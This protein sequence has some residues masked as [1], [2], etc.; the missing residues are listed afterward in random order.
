VQNRTIGNRQV[1]AIGLGGMPMS[2]EGRPEREQSIA[3]IHAALDAGITL[4]DT[5]DAYCLDEDDKHHNEAL[6]RR[7]LA[8]FPGDTSQV[9]VAT[10]GGLVRPGGRWERYGDPAHLRR[11]IRESHQALGGDRPIG[12]W[13]LHAPD[14]AWTLAEMLEPV[15]EA[16]ERGLVQYVGLSNVTLAELREAQRHVEI[17]SVQNQYNPW[18]READRSGLLAAC[19]Q[20][21]LVFLPWGPL[22]GSRRV[23]RLREIAALRELADEHEVSVQRVVLAWLLSRS[24]AMLPIP[25][26]S[27]IESVEDSVAADRVALRADEIA[28]IDRE[29]LPTT[30][31]PA[32]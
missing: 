11:T 3:T 16:Q 6:V 21:G 23:T 15:R 27:R 4:I 29:T 7:A 18:E 22:G 25:G 8:S 17:V 2:I 31:R 20:E 14:P 30:A 9:V 1:S 10:K 12:L 24:P 19:E 5:A 28:R 13:Q 32:S 26:A